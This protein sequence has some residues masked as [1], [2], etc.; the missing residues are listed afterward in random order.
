MYYYQY[1]GVLR[2]GR[3]QEHVTYVLKSTTAFK[4]KDVAECLKFQES[5]LR[6]QLKFDSILINKLTYLTEPMAVAL[7]KQRG[8]SLNSIPSVEFCDLAPGLHT[9]KG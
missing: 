1:D 3:R 6:T 9:K 2:D 8:M 5:Y 4:G 7:M